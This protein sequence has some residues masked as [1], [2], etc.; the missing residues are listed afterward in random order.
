MAKTSKSQD[1]SHFGNPPLRYYNTSLCESKRS[2]DILRNIFACFTKS[3][4]QG[5]IQAN[6][7][8]FQAKRKGRDSPSRRNGLSRSAAQG[9][10]SSG[11]SLRTRSRPCGRP[12]CRTR[13]SYW[14]CRRCSS[15]GHSCPPYSGSPAPCSARS[16]S[17]CWKRR[18]PSPGRRNSTSGHSRGPCSPLPGCWD[19]SSSHPGNSRSSS[20]HIVSW[21]SSR[22]LSVKPWKNT[23]KLLCSAMT[24]FAGRIRHR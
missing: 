22:H 10:L 23:G 19:G 4:S 14:L 2:A 12:C 18:R 8:I 17:S 5:K 7:R 21:S 20:H 1:N 11:K 9:A 24:S 13:K 6:Q 16:R 3:A 15:G